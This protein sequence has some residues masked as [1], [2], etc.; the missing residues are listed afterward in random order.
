MTRKSNEWLTENSVSHTVK[1]V[2]KMIA[3]KGDSIIGRQWIFEKLRHSED[4]VRC[5]WNKTIEECFTE[6]GS[7][8][9]Q[10]FKQESKNIVASASGDRN[11]S[12]RRVAREVLEKEKVTGESRKYLQ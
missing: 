4:Q 10:M 2:T 1:Y 7:G 11:S 12:C 3:R 5:N 8:L 9:P 6:F